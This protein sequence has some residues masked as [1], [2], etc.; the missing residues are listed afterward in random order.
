MT[1]QGYMS[2]PPSRAA[3]I[4]A[5]IFAAVLALIS[6]DTGYAWSE[7]EQQ[8]ALKDLP[9]LLEGAR[10]GELSCQAALCNIY[11][12]EGRLQD[13]REACR[14]CTR[15]AE[16]KHAQSACFLAS[17]Y[18]TGRGVKK[19]PLMEVYWL[20]KAASW[21]MA[22]AQWALG[23]VYLY[24]KDQPKDPQ[25][26]IQLFR[27]AAAAGFAS[28]QYDLGLCYATG[29]GVMKDTDKALEWLR[30]AA[31]NGSDKARRMLQNLQE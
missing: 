10:K 17:L 18:G 11:Y 7:K 15:A 30:K 8:M 5:A 25:A 21:G 14:W 31:S 1:Y 26:A 24:G 23:I 13:Y 27:K 22:D 20:K 12:G 6:V 16:Q 29:R 9:I 28:A 19:D 3:A 2:V 4:S